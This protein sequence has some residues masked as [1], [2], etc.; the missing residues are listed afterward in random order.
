MAA[1]RENA[2]FLLHIERTIYDPSLTGFPNSSFFFT[3]TWICLLTV[4][5]EDLTIAP[6]IVIENVHHNNLHTLGTLVIKKKWQELLSELS[7][8]KTL[9]LHD[10]DP[11]CASVLKA[12]STSED[13]VLPHL[14]RVIIVSSAIHSATFAHSDG[15]APAPVVLW[16]VT[17][18]CSRM[19]Q[20]A[21]SCLRL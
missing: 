10:G 12:L 3:S 11:A 16:Q 8:V 4:N 19:C 2:L 5:I 1:R 9:H 18:S 7:S 15:V 13:P 17:I 6:V 20:W 14:Q 21:W